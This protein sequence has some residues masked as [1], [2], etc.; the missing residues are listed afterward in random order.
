[1]SEDNREDKEV[2]KMLKTFYEYEYFNS[3]YEL[4]EFLEK[5]KIKPKNIIMIECAGG[6]WRLIYRKG[7]R[8]R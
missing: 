5:A 4:K 2:I 1:M 7:R 8:C 3:A 6:R